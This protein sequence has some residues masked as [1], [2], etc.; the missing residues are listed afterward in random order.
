L[1]KQDSYGGNES[2]PVDTV[3]PSGTTDTTSVQEIVASGDA[4]DVDETKTRLQ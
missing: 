4:S 3:N 2:A 1:E